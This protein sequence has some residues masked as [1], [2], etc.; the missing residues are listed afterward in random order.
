MSDQVNSMME[1]VRKLLALADS[2]KTTEGEATAAALKIQELVQTYGLDL[3]LIEGSVPAKE[4]RGKGTVD[5]RAMFEY[6]Q[7]LMKTIAENNFCF[8]DIR[9]VFVERKNRNSKQHFLVGR[10]LNIDV[11]LR[12]YDYLIDAMKRLCERG[13]F[14]EHKTR[15][16]FYDGA[17]ERLTER[18]LEQR[19]DREEDER[20]KR[21]EARRRG[22]QVNA[23]VLADV[24][25]TERDLNNDAINNYAPGTT[26]QRRMNAERME[27]ERRV[28][29][30][31]LRDQGVEKTVAYYMSHGYEKEKAVGYAQSYY[32]KVE[33]AQRRQSART[34]SHK[35][36]TQGDREAYKR[37]SSVAFK[38]G[39]EAAKNIGLDTQ[40]GNK[41]QGLLK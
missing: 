2:T 36:F 32:E 4:V 6:Q 35:G 27:A 23:L 28:R 41:K 17:T 34:S 25:G 7:L 24:Y 3:A 30:K 37:R 12:M 11:T 26:A 38:A 39:N 8:H 22:E 21:E 40:I 29:E 15:N 14:Q 13:G 33:Q 19:R 18:L 10:Q 16:L 31:E 1:N 9:T 20:L 5:R